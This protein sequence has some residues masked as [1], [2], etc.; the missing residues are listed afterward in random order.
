MQISF[1]WSIRN[2]IDRNNLFPE[3]PF[4]LSLDYIHTMNGWF[5]PFDRICAVVVA[6]P[7]FHSRNTI[8]LIVGPKKGHSDA[9]LYSR[10]FAF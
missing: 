2:A 1:I 8:P 6:P 10:P 5:P 7:S 3:Y 9:P 4:A